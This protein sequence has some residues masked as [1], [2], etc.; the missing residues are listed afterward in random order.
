MIKTHEDLYNFEQCHLLFYL[1][2]L[3]VKPGSAVI[4]CPECGNPWVVYG[5]DIPEGYDTRKEWP[6]MAS[7]RC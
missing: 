7:A 2:R 3:G 6:E 5:P 4:K 1:E